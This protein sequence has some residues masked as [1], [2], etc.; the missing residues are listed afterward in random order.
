[1]SK[2]RDWYWKI[3]GRGPDY[4]FRASF[5]PDDAGR[6]AALLRKRPPKGFRLYPA[7]GDGR[8]P[9]QASAAFDYYF[10]EYGY[11]EMV[12]ACEG[13]LKRNVWRYELVRVCGP[14]LEVE[15]V[16]GGAEG[17]GL[18]VSATLLTLARSPEFTWAGWAVTYGGDGYLGGT[19]A[20]GVTGADLISYLTG[21]GR[22]AGRNG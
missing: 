12:A 9:G 20:V 14:N 5:G 13:R 17:D 15:R 10:E 11:E 16:F 21:A 2:L 8:L 19:A 3:G 22:G 4:N 6:L 18:N 1:M 7:G